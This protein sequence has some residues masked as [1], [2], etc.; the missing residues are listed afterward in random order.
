MSSQAADI[1]IAMLH[2]TTQIG[3]RSAAAIALL[4]Y[5]STSVAGTFRY[6]PVPRALVEG[7][8]R[9][10]K[11]DNQQR[12]EKLKQM[13]AQAGCGTHELSDQSVKDSKI[14]NVVCVLPG[15][16]DKTIIVGAHFDHVR[17]SE[18]VVDNL[19]GASL[20]PSLY[21]AV[22]AEP[23][24][25]TY[26]FIGFTDE[27]LGEVGSHYYA[28]AMTKQEVA[29]TDA[30]VNMDTLGLATT[31]VWASHSDGQLSAILGYIAKRLNMPVAAVNVDQVGSSDSV[32]FAARK[33]PVSPCTRSHRKRS[34]PEFCILRRITFRSFDLTITIRP[35]SCLPP[36][37][38][39]WI[40]LTNRARVPSSLPILCEKLPE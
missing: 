23:R 21:E 40:S 2:R 8:L 33:I 34:M 19:S 6:N 5:S 36:I 4:A 22:K 12:H 24:K 17:M 29:A 26:I 13:F 28:S 27:E 39:S 1:L 7:R 15:T 18:G 10:Y 14:P 31:E 20:L 3:L 35:I 9:N 38:P 30:M 37:S 16:S 25:H 11:G 32:Q